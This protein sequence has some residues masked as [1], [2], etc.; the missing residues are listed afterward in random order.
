MLWA[1][2]HRG[3]ELNW[4]NAGKT[5]MNLEYVSIESSNGHTQ[6]IG[7]QYKEGIKRYWE[8]ENEGTLAMKWWEFSRIDMWYMEVVSVSNEL[9]DLLKGL[10]RQH[11][12]NACELLLGT[13]DTMW[14]K[15]ETE[16]K[17]AICKGPTIYCILK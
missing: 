6:V 17:M 5:W 8:L 3:W 14:Q 1:T 13:H 16:E 11:M 15:W 12:E 4:F 9:Y 7:L 2:I 10:S